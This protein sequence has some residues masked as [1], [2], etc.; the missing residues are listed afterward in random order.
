MSAAARRL[1]VT[2]PY[3]SG[4]TLCDKR[5]HQHPALCVASQPAPA[6]FVQAKAA[7]LEARELRRRYPLDHGFGEVDYR[8]E[9][10]AEHLD[11][12]PWDEARIAGLF[13]ALRGDGSGHWT[14][15]VLDL[16]SRLRPGPMGELWEQLV[17]ALPDVLGRPD[18][19]VVGAKEILC[20]EY[21]P[22][23][24]A[25]GVFVLVVLRDPRDVLLSVQGG[26]SARYVGG[27]RPT[28]HVLRTWR[29]GVAHALA[30][31][32][33]PRFGWL[34]YEDLVADPARA[35][36]PT[37]ARLGVAP[38]GPEAFAG[39]LLDQRGVAW[40]GNSSFARSPRP[41][42]SPATRRFVEAACGPELRALGYLPVEALRPE[43]R[44]LDEFEEP[45]PTTH[46]AFEPG[47][48]TDRA[49]LSAEWRRLEGV[50]GD[51]PGSA[52]DVA[53]TYLHPAAFAALRRAYRP[54]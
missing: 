38:L 27:R 36:A 49:R 13:G 37:F 41:G 34:R 23:L 42:L 4:T 26:E 10:F 6:L 8:P 21:T 43:R 32:E 11:R 44:W 9:D 52:L 54:E 31:A 1:F 53:A 48:S 19:A 28:L 30:H 47:Y 51:A 46:A 29:K 20:E 18:A 45:A 2:G 5:L 50:F 17:D 35:L 22:W 33:H 15:E 39:P 24:L 16:E 12:D 3:R 14:P 40:A 25:R 7:F